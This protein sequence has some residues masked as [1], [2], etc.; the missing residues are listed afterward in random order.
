MEYA[1]IVS[2]ILIA[3]TYAIVVMKIS[4]KA[5]LAPMSPIDQ[6]QNYILGGIVGGVLFSKSITTMDFVFV[7]TLWATV[8][9]SLNYARKKSKHVKHLIDGSIIPVIHNG[10]VIREGIEKAKMPLGDLYL[11]LRSQK[12]FDIESVNYAQVEQ[13]G[14][15]TVLTRDDEERL[16][17]LLVVD[18]MILDD[19][20]ERIDKDRTW[21]EEVLKRNDIQSLHDIASIE[22]YQGQVRII[23]FD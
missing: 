1:A 11:K 15:L 18:K 5:N 8:S 6:L 4:G 7:M 12:I 21:L 2:K 23:H 20:L 17:I 13:N 22:M 10:V 9:L 3:I 14:Q 19:G 16:P